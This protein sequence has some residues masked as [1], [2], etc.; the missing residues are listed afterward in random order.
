MGLRPRLARLEA[1]AEEAELGRRAERLAAELGV[2]VREVLAELRRAT[3]WVG[4]HWRDSSHAGH[5][6]TVGGRP[7]LE[8][9]IRAMAE[10][11]GHEPDAAV[12]EARAIV[13][14]GDR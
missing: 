3:A 4:R 10:E 12:A 5:A 6:R 8:P 9:C 2:P 7:D 13:A 11:M 14:R 1:L